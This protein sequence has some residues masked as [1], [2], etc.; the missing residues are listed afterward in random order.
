MFG[1]F[2]RAVVVGN[3]MEVKKAHIATS[4]WLLAKFAGSGPVS[5]LLFTLSSLRIG[6]PVRRS[7]IL[8]VSILLAKSRT[9]NS[10]HFYY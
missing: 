10:S 7:S 2:D 1:F 6:R 3:V 5:W 9:C 4:I 8:P